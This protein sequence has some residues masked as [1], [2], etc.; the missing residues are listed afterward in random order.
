MTMGSNFNWLDVEV[1]D[2]TGTFT[3]SW[4]GPRLASVWSTLPNINHHD[5]TCMYNEM[6]AKVPKYRDYPIRIAIN[7]PQQ[8][9]LIKTTRSPLPQT[10][11]LQSDKCAHCVQFHHTCHSD[12]HGFLPLASDHYLPLFLALLAAQRPSR[13]VAPVLPVD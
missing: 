6:Q 9:K 1:D 11:L 4:F 13:P 10:C 7:P 8:Y 12:V 2:S 3:Q 5:I